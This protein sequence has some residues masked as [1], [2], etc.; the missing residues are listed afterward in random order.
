MSMKHVATG[1]QF[2]D[3]DAERVRISKMHGYDIHVVWESE[4]KQ[5]KEIVM[6]R[7][8]EFLLG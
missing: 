7:C 2:W 3:Y 6:K 5:D 8:K 1:Q 4:W